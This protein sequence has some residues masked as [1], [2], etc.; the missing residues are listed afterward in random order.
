MDDDVTG[1]YDPRSF[2]PRARGQYSLV[3]SYQL[4]KISI[5]A[6]KM[7]HNAREIVI[8]K[9]FFLCISLMWFP[10]S[11]VSM[12]PGVFLLQM[13]FFGFVRSYQR[14]QEIG[15]ENN[16]VKNKLLCSLNSKIKSNQKK[17]CVSRKIFFF[18]LLRS[19]FTFIHYL[20]SLS[21]GLVVQM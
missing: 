13:F 7:R 8:L 11:T 3:R 4:T 14:L 2:L 15:E 6:R 16:F 19:L 21:R 9:R 1:E 5:L 18:F 12:F 20:C 17:F 10:S